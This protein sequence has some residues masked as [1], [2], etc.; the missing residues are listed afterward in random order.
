MTTRKRPPRSTEAPELP[1]EVV[2]TKRELG[3]SPPLSPIPDHLD[4]AKRHAPVRASIA[5][6]TWIYAGIGVIIILGFFLIWYLM[7]RR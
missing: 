5:P 4:P 3:P 6:E 1:P 7:V 2:E